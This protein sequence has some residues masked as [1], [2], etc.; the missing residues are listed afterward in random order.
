MLWPVFYL[1]FETNALEPPVIPPHIEVS[2]TPITTL[3]RDFCRVSG[4]DGSFVSGN[5]HPGYA[6]RLGRE[7]SL[8][9]EEGRA[10]DL[11]AHLRAPRDVASQIAR[12]AKIAETGHPH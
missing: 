5:V 9:S 1:A 10:G 6:D 12:C 7:P 3:W 11:V 2:E 4:N 8:R